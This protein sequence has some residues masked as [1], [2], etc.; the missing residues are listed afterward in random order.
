M[1][2]N[3][4]VM[5]VVDLH[6]IFYCLLCMLSRSPLPGLAVTTHLLDMCATLDTGRLTA[7]SILGDG[8]YYMHLTAPCMK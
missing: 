4:S 1:K 3:T 5:C 8:V 6:A 7:T 2:R